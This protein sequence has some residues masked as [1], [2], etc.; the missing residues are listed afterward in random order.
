MPSIRLKVYDTQSSDY[1]IDE[2]VDVQTFA[3]I[4]QMIPGYNEQTRYSDA[5][6]KGDAFA[7]VDALVTRDV[8][9]FQT[10][11]KSKAGK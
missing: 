1:I 4:Q 11:S 6:T 5:T 10:P 3:D 9:I 7:N 2:D 8:T